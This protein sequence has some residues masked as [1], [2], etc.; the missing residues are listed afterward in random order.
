MK[1]MKSAWIVFL[2]LDGTLWDHLDI[3]ATIPPF[4]RISTSVIS[5]TRGVNITLMPGAVEFMK[6]V[7]ANGGILS[8]CS[9]NE[10]DKAMGAI[11]AYELIHLFSFQEISTNPGKYLLMEELISKL[12]NQ[13][14]SI[15]ENRLFYLDDRDIHVKDVKTMFPELTFFHMWK[16]GLDFEDVEKTISSKIYASK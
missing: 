11:Q 12:R 4:T 15:Q 6:W 1:V 3:T 8:S 5:D 14:M 7:R 9:W 2:D 16:D 13:G 10:Y